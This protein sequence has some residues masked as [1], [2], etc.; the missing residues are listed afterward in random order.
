[1]L[2]FV[3]EEWF[4]GVLY[5]VVGLGI[6]AFLLAVW[7]YGSAAQQLQS[8][9]AQQLRDSGT[10]INPQTTQQA[11]GI[12][13]ADLERRALIGQ[14]YQAMMIGGSGLILIALGWIGMNIRR[15]HLHIPTP[16]DERVSQ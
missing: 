9:L 5:A 3:N 8:N 16:A 2:K 15:R 7:Q 10:E 13:A 1:M 4:R 6:L 11:R 14:Q 12:V